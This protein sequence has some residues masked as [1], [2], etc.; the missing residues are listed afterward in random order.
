VTC[1]TSPRDAGQQGF[2]GQSDEIE[3]CFLQQETEANRIG[4]VH[5][6]NPL[7]TSCFEAAALPGQLKANAFR[8]DIHRKSLLRIA[9]RTTALPI[10][11]SLSRSRHWAC[12]HGDE[13]SAMPLG[14]GSAIAFRKVRVTQNE[15]GTLG[16]V[17]Y[18]SH[19]GTA[20]IRNLSTH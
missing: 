3:R 16:E 8:C 14:F 1:I 2:I 11:I 18:D 13:R 9:S 6:L 7:K 5:H 15:M 17:G 19:H 12:I 10:H 20:D 4:T